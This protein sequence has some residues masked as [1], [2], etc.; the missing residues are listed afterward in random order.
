MKEMDGNHLKWD[1]RELTQPMQINKKHKP[2]QSSNQVSPCQNNVRKKDIRKS[3]C[4]K[5]AQNGAVIAWNDK[6]L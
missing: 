5:N 2:K 1:Q 4:A 6:Y 3:Y